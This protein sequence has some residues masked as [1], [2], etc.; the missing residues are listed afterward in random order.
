MNWFKIAG[1]QFGMKWEDKEHNF[2]QLRELISSI[3]GKDLI[4][5]PETFSTG[6]TMKSKLYC[7]ER[8]GQT[9]SFLLEMSKKTNALVGGGWI[10]ANSNGLPYNTFSLVSP[11][12]NFW[13]Y[14]KIHPFSFAKED[15]YFSAGS[16]VLTFAWRGVNITPLVCY[17]LRFPEIFRSSV[18]KTDL[19]AVIGNW[20]STRI[21][22]WLALLKARAIENQAYTI[23]VNRVGVAGKIK[24]LS[25]NGYSGFFSPMGT[26]NILQS[27]SQDILE[28]SFSVDELKRVRDEFPYLKDIRGV[29][30]N[31]E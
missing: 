7:E 6:F 10:E 13:R 11:E 26:E 18:G 31:C 30:F 12:G 16:E 2:S 4:L 24:K 8:L 19:F 22:H 28:V 27:E 21:H 15:Q 9:E 25:H 29:G 5:L 17:D 23:G 20:P 1:I 3:T 14:R